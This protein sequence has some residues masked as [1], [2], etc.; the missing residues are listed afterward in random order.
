MGTSCLLSLGLSFISKMKVND[1]ITPQAL[2]SSVL[3][4]LVSVLPGGKVA[5]GR[6]PMMSEK[7]RVHYR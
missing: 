4:D 2:L 7:D 5:S 6:K 3:C 1:W